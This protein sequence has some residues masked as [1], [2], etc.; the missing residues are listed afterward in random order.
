MMGVKMK[1]SKIDQRGQALIELIIF[2]PLIFT[3]YGL[4]GGFA[5]AINGSI[6]QQKITRSY[7][8]FRAQNNSS[9]P[10]PSGA[11]SFQSWKRFGMFFIG[12][13]DREIDENSPQPYS[14][15]YQ[16]SFPVEGAASDKCENPYNKITTQFI[17]VG[18]VYGTCG[19]TFVTVSGKAVYAPEAGA[20][21]QSVLDYGACAI[22]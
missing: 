13:S 21:F 7:F 17:R 2:L 10:K 16:I 19:N 15:C 11:L 6:N 9:M 5:N 12:W 18:T 22:E 3:L 14:A 4:I 20:G 8:Y 1:I